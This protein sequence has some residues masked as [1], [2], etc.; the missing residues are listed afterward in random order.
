[1]P[2]SV[3]DNEIPDQ[4][5]VMRAMAPH[6]RAFNSED[7]GHLS[8]ESGEESLVSAE[9][10]ELAAGSLAYATEI[11]I[12]EMFM[13]VAALTTSDSTVADEDVVT[14]SLY[15]L[16]Q[17]YTHFY[18]AR[19]ARH[20]LVT[21]VAMTS[22]FASGGSRMLS[23]TAEELALKMILEQAETSLELYELNSP[24]VTRALAFF[25]ENAYEDL[26]HE[27]LYHVRSARRN[28][29]TRSQV[30]AWFD[31]FNPDRPVHLFALYEKKIMV[32]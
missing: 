32:S 5:P 27:E 15:A 29:E 13:D 23:S 16:P 6:F 2:Q 20:F 19:F 22:R 17:A 18:D 30:K 10:A 25:K 31:P 4:E 8:E 24:G 9:D 12:D 28:K 7:F 21:T 1:M 3:F 14:M 11:V 26:D